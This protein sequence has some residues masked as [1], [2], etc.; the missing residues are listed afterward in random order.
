MK[1]PLKH[2][3]GVTLI[4]LMVVL[5]IIAILAAVGYPYMT[6]WF[7][8]RRLVGAIEGV[9]SH[10]NLA[11]T[12]AIKMGLP[13]DQALYLRVQGGASWCLAISNELNCNCNTAG[14]CLYGLGDNQEKTFS[15]A[16]F[17]GITMSA[18]TSGVDIGLDSRRGS[19][20]STP[21]VTTPFAIEL[22]SPSGLALQVQIGRLGGIRTCSPSGTMGYPPC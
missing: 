5:M 11:R 12:E 21:A 13:E 16:A 10:I 20:S 7:E 19:V 4:E 2:R 17:P 1:R 8:N 15:A 14:S 22:T 18:P 9:Q 6:G 3:N